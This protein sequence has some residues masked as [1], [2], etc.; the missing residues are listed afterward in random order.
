[1]IKDTGYSPIRALEV[2]GFKLKPLT[3]KSVPTVC[4][5]RVRPL[6]FAGPSIL[7]LDGKYRVEEDRYRLGMVRKIKAGYFVVGDGKEIPIVRLWT[8]EHISESE[9]WDIAKQILYMPRVLSRDGV[10]IGSVKDV[11]VGFPVKLHILILGASGK[12]KS[13][14][15]ASLLSKI[16]NIY[17]YRVLVLDWYGEYSKLP[18]AIV[19]L[20]GR[21]IRVN[22]FERGFISGWDVI[23]QV[24]YYESGEKPFSYIQFEIALQAYERL[25][26]EQKPLTASNLM[27]ALYELKL[28]RE[29][30]LNAR[31]ALR[32]RLLRLVGEEF[33]ET[34]LPPDD[35]GLY[36][37]DLSYFASDFEKMVFSW[38]ILQNLLYNPPE[39]DTVIV[40]DEAQRYAPRFVRAET[41]LDRIM[42]EGRKLGIKVV[43]ATQTASDL[44]S[45]VINNADVIV[46]FRCTG[47]DAEIAANS[48]SP[49]HAYRLKGEIET[50]EVGE[51]LLSISGRIMKIRVEPEYLPYPRIN[52]PARKDAE[53]LKFLKYNR[54]YVYILTLWFVSD[55]LFSPLLYVFV[56]LSPDNTVTKNKIILPRLERDKFV[57]ALKKTG[58]REEDAEKLSR[59]TARSLTVLRR[60]LSPVSE[61]PEWAKPERAIEILPVLLIGKW[62]ENKQGDKEIVSEI[63]GIPYNVFTGNIKKWLYKPDPPI[64]KI[65]EMWRL[66]SP[67]DAFFALSP[68]LTKNHFEKLKKV[69]LKVLREI[70]PSLDLEPEKRWMASAYGKE[71][72]YS[73]ILREG[74]AQTLILIAVFGNDKNIDLPYPPQIWVDGVFHELLNNADWKLWYSLSDVLRFVAEASPS[75]FLD[76]VEDSL[77]QKPPSIMGMFSETDDILTSHSAHPSLLWALEGLAWDPDLLGRVAVIL[78]KLAKLDP[79]GKLANRPINSLRNI[80]LLWLPHTY[81]TLKQ[82]L[83][84][85][86][87][88]I[89]REPEIGWKLLISLMPRSHD[90]CS[91]THKPRWR[92][93][94]NKADNRVTIKE[95]RESISAIVDKI[96]KNVGKDGKKWAEIMGHYSGL[97]LQEREKILRELSSLVDLIDDS[98]L[99]LWNKLR[100]IL[101][102]HR[103]FHD[104]KWAL[105]EKELRE[106]EEI[107]NKLEPADIVKRYIWLFEDDWPRLP[108]GK[109]RNDYKKFEQ[110]VAQKRI[111]TIQD[112][113][114]KLGMKGLIKLAEE[115]KNPDI[116]G[117]ITAELPFAD[118][119]EEFLFS[120]L[121]AEDKKVAFIQGYIG[122]K[123]FKNGDTWIKEVVDKALLEQWDSIK[124]INLFL[125]LPQN[126]R[127]WN[128]LEKFKTQVQKEYWARIKPVFFDLP[129]EDEIYALQKVMYVKR[130]FTSLYTSAVFAKEVPPKLVV[131]LLEKAAIERSSDDFRIVKPW[132]IEQLFKIL[133]QSDEIEKDK[134]AKLE[135]LYLPILGRL[136]S[137]RRPKMLHQQLSKNPEFFTEVIKCVYKPKSENG[138]EAEEDIPEEF[139]EQRARVAWELLHT[140]KTVPG[141]DS[142]GR[143]DYQKLKSWVEKAREL[144]EKLDRLEVCDTHIGQVLAYSTPDEDGNWPPEE[145]CRIIEEIESKNLEEG[146]S[147]GI[148]NK[149][150]VVTKSPFEGGQQERELAEQYRKYADR[151]NDTYPKVASILRKIGEYYEFVARRE[152]KEAEKRGLEW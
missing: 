116:V 141:S 101:S 142:R 104:A 42:R 81:A 56:P 102:D 132:H 45:T 52:A 150:G 1:M 38:M 140:W 112:I 113:R 82:R 31:A 110:I 17:D 71:G 114:V 54:Q 145:V 20:P 100:E 40:M 67:I 16:L 149:R 39:K 61:Q 87:T 131:E 137:K 123:A 64:L 126:R 66:T 120:L 106:I 63:A 130:H 12:G 43:A 144:C 135:W 21:D 96:L 19:L 111:K 10:R 51:C 108:E 74:I 72:K 121:S 35:R 128:L 73:R 27:E 119:E 28:D 46:V 59:D 92:Q 118:N 91:P 47:E 14:L 148:Y 26:M 117:T 57:S 133:D 48:L 33:S 68:F 134:I 86:D 44:R 143:I 80:F 93:V 97:P 50:L 69:S 124:V 98:Q 75:S 25:S 9:A 129:L 62:D 11:D 18:G 53:M 138:E 30:L 115:S 60:R 15:I 79:G 65:G 29:D 41:F 58:I 139:K 103:S 89:R 34:K 23:E 3:P 5:R 88:L 78:G 84:V 22:P 77:S 83:G 85:M 49:S 13:T 55:I 105:P 95:Y 6:G 109:E 24:L 107:Y 36:V 136:G 146:F 151:W 122:R 127:I 8:G 125:A 94:S 147:I 2:L 70:D 99:G 32:R 37:A 152:D 76:A 7:V 90:F 4:C